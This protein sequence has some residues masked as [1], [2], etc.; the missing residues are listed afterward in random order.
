M[1]SLHTLL[2]LESLDEPSPTIRKK[3]VLHTYNRLTTVCVCVL[4]TCTGKDFITR[5]WIWPRTIASNCRYTV[6]QASAVTRQVQ[7]IQV[8]TMDSHVPVVQPSNTLENN[9]K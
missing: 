9:G 4:S 3:K 7:V 1:K 5:D 6:I 8:D 2:C